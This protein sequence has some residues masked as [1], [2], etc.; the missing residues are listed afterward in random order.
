[1]YEDHWKYGEKEERDLSALTYIIFYSLFHI[2]MKNVLNNA[3]YKL[4]IDCW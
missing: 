2:K 1:M 3:R 4:E